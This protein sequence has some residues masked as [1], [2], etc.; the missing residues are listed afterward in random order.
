[1]TTT[2]NQK[3]NRKIIGKIGETLAK[4]VLLKKG[5]EIL[6]TNWG[7]KWGEIDIIAKQQATLVFVEVKTKT[8]TN[9]G[10][11]E[12]MISARKLKQITKMA[13][14]YPQENNQTKRIDVIAVIL[15]TVCRPTNIRHYR[16]VY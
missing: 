8:G 16:A 1:M 12:T 15:D 11:P 10:T 9:F 4:K 14:T 2:K 7:N 6:E 3:P 13:E 5:Y